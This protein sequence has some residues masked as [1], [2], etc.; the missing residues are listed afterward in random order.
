[1]L[2]D[3]H[4]QMVPQEPRARHDPP[5]AVLLVGLAKLAEEETLDTA[6]ARL[7]TPEKTAVLADRGG[8][9][10][11]LALTQSPRTTPAP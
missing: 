5:D 3:A 7:T 8:I 4:R 1:M 9:D 2:L 6:L 11:L 10:R